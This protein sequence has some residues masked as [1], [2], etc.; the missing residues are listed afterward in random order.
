MIIQPMMLWIQ[1]NA[2]PI[3]LSWG[4]YSIN[5]RRQNNVSLSHWSA[6]F[7]AATPRL[8]KC[9]HVFPTKGVEQQQKNVSATAA[10]NITI[11]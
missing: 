11:K 1:L 2:T 5:R 9:F 3:V 8:P 6:N 4:F 7:A 10:A